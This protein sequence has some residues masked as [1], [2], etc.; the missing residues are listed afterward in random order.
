M[1]A[2]S[3]TAS[4]I[5]YLCMGLFSCLVSA[6]SFTGSQAGNK[7]YKW[8]DAF[9]RSGKFQTGLAIFTMLLLWPVHV[10]LAW[11]FKP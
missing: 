5:L 6:L 4:S 9:A 2:I 7:Y 10:A 8:I 3:I 11:I 1:L